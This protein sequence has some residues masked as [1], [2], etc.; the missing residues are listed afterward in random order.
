MHLMTFSIISDSQNHGESELDENQRAC[1]SID[2][3]GNNS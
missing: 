3:Q 2:E 1:D